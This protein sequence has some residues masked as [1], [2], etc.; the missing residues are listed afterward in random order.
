MGKLK[1]LASVKS[2]NASNFAY[3]P[4][5]SAFDAMRILVKPHLDYSSENPARVSLDIL[6]AVLRGL[7]RATP[8]GRIVVMDGIIDE[9]GVE[10]VFEELGIISLLD[11]EM[12]IT[13]SDNLI[14]LNYP[15][16]LSDPIIYPSM[17]ASGYIREYDCVISLGAFKRTTQNDKVEISASLHNL[18]GIFPQ[19]KYQADFASANIDDL[20][21]DIYF[22][23]GHHIDGAVID[24]SQK[25]LGDDNT[26]YPVGRVVWGDD[27]LAVDEVAC[28]LADE[29]V[30][31]Y[32]ENIRKRRKTLMG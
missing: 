32:I 5:D 20:L 15:N 3:L 23:I 10:A 22:T 7:R 24:L 11:K 27:L 25:Y 6:G 12:R 1:D 21:T 13:D 28:Q 18:M 4:P 8:L 17:T 31:D 29:P 16:R 14:M 9:K 30:P 26:A 19:E 2:T